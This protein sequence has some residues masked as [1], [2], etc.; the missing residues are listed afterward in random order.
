MQKRID[1]RNVD[2][3]AA[4]PAP[5]NWASLSLEERL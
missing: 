5:S 2:L 4:L 3:L 1:E